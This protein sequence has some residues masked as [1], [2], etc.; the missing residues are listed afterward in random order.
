M[1]TKSK[2]IWLWLGLLI[3]ADLA[4]PWHVVGQNDTFAGPFLFWVVWT[5]VAIVSM[6]LVFRRWSS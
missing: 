2:L 4:V 6:F 1:T 3:V 5:A